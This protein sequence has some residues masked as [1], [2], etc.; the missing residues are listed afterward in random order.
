MPEVV[1][2]ASLLS[3]QTSQLLVVD[4]Q[5]KLIPVIDGHQRVTSEINL[6][7]NAAEILSVPATVSEQYPAG[8]GATIP[9]IGQHDA[10]RRRFEKLKFSAADDFLGSQAEQGFEHNDRPWQVVLVGIETHICILQTALDLQHSGWNIFVVANAVG[11]RRSIDHEVG[12]NRMLSAGITVVTTE[13]V[14][15]EWCETAG[16]D[17]FRQISRLV[18]SHQS[19]D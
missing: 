5:E 16:T 15:F 4:V 17:Q 6:L 3:R 10:I 19:V 14:L 2:S 1:R 12:L 13:S 11:S 9:E 7:L 18:R 8:L